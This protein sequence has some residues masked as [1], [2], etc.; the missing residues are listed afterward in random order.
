MANL[1]QSVREAHFISSRYF[2]LVKKEK[3]LCPAQNWICEMCSVIKFSPLSGQSF[4]LNDRHMFGLFCLLFF[5]FNLKTT[6]SQFSVVTWCSQPGWIANTWR[7]LKAT[8]SASLSG[9]RRVLNASRVI[10]TR[11]GEENHWSQKH[12]KC[13]LGTLSR[14]SA[15]WV[16]ESLW[17]LCSWF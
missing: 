15:L 3:A 4:F 8:W 10:F 13:C 14:P 17:D 5:V 7:V 16:R 12:A 6:I 11:A 1:S 2:S 9:R